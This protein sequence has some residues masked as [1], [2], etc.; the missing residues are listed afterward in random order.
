M[1]TLLEKYY[2]GC[3]SGIIRKFNFLMEKGKRKKEKGKRKKEKRKTKKRKRRNEN[4][5]VEAIARIP[6]MAA[7]PNR[8]LRKIK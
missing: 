5:N 7:S 1:G 4:E 2:V 6:K 8:S 3:I